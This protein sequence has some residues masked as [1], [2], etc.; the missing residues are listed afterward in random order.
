[1]NF[2]EFII[3]QFMKFVELVTNKL[4]EI[5][6]QGMEQLRKIKDVITELTIIINNWLIEVF[7]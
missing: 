6:N 5:L 1:M 4:P 3:N 7:K 2:R